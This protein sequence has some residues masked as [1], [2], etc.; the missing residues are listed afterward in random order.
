[1]SSSS[2]RKAGEP[3]GDPSVANPRTFLPVNCIP[4][5]S[6]PVNLTTSA[7]HTLDVPTATIPPELNQLNPWK[8]KRGDVKKYLEANKEEYNLEDEDITRLYEERV[9]G[10]VLLLLTKNELTTFY[11]LHRG[12]AGTIELLSNA[13]TQPQASLLVSKRTAFNAFPEGFEPQGTPATG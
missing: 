12:T 11:G 5:D 4:A 7:S 2:K 13:L 6:T 10:L 3:P 8:W 1:M 9:S